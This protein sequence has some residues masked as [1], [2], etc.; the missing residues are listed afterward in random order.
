MC[1][2]VFTTNPDLC[3]TTGQ[4][5]QWQVTH[6]LVISTILYEPVRH[7]NMYLGNQSS[8]VTQ[9]TLKTSQHYVVCPVNLPCS[10]TLYSLHPN[11][12]SRK[13]EAHNATSHYHACALVL[14]KLSH[15]KCV[16]E[17]IR[18][19][20]NNLYPCTCIVAVI[21]GDYR[22][23]KRASE[24][25]ISALLSVSDVAYLFLSTQTHS[26]RYKTG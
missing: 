9:S 25:L 14:T 5:N 22:L 6:Y 20:L 16:A 15:L 4:G 26:D 13:L 17:H 18:D 21:I 19:S 1:N 12:N 23:F 2:V 8:I 11:W 24:P 7:A 3:S 10:G